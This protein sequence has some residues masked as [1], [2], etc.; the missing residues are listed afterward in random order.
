MFKTDL[1]RTSQYTLSVKTTF[2][3]RKSRLLAI[4]W[5]N[6]VQSGTQQMTLWLMCIA[7]WVPLATNTHSQYIVLLAFPPRKWLNESAS[8]LR[9]MYISCLVLNW[10]LRTNII[11]TQREVKVKLFLRTRWSDGLIRSF[12]TSTLEEGEPSVSRPSRF[13]SR[14]IAG[15]THRK[16]RWKE[17]RTKKDNIFVKN[18]RLI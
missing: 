15:A 10:L 16:G 18:E 17:Y 14:E 2:F 7:C 5:K 6:V 1:Y 8:V 9:F 11:Q 13:P 12:F 3:L 4:M